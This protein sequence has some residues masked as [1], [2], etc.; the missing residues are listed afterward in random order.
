[1]SEKARWPLELTAWYRSVRRE[2][3]WRQDPQPYTVWISEIMLQQTRIEAVLGYYER[4]MAA[5]PTVEALAAADEAAVLKLWEGLG[6]YSR[7]R[8]LHKAARGITG[9]FRKHMKP[10]GRCRASGI[11]R[12]GRSPRLRWDSPE[13]RSMAM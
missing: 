9:T 10:F 11:I 6:Y 12:P 8:N 7:A 1:M 4:F 13:R 3:P 2:Y 5:F